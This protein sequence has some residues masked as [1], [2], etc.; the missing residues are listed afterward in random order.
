MTGKPSTH[1]QVQRVLAKYTIHPAANL[2]PMID[3]PA[4]EELAADLKA[5]GQQEP[6]WADEHGAILDGR[7][8]LVGCAVAGIEPVIEPWEPRDGQTPT[9][10][11]LSKN[12]HRRHL[13]ASQRAAVAVEME[14]LIAA[15]NARRKAE[16][17]ANRT[18]AQQA[19]AVAR[20]ASETAASLF[21]DAPRPTRFAT[22]RARDTA[23]QA[24]GVSSGYVNDAKDLRKAAPEVY[25]DVKAG[26][27]TLPTAQDHVV[28]KAQ[29]AGTLDQVG[30]RPGTVRTVLARQ[31]KAASKGKEPKARIKLPKFSKV[32]SSRATIKATMTFGNATVAEEWLNRLQD[33]P[34]CLSLDFEAVPESKLR[35][36]KSAAS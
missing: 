20:S 19:K 10:F 18:P 15:E 2:F 25:E 36:R 17:R 7:N 23:A 14:P 24:M 4:M 26:R 32:A 35:R 31:E 3:A 5:N 28:A 30:L 34:R 29:E 22:G 6:V 9:A 33:D 16:R 8:R 1:D 13:T 12:L 27:M 21:S 11:V